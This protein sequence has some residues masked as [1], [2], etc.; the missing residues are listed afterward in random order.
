MGI[1]YYPNSTVKMR[2]HVVEKLQK[3]DVVYSVFGSHDLSG[4]ALSV[5]VWGPA[6]WEIK[7]VSL[8]FSTT[9]SKNYS[10]SIAHGVGIVSGKNDRLW[11]KVDAVPAQQVIVPQGFYSGS[12]LTDALETALNSADLSF[13]AESVPFSVSFDSENLLLIEPA[14]GKAKVLMLNPRVPVRRE[15]TLAPLLGFTQDSFNTETIVSDV[16]AV[17]MGLMDPKTVYLSAAGSAVQN[18]VGTD[19][20]AM[21]VDNQLLIESALTGGGNCI[22]TYEVVYKM[23]DA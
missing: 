23:L 10:L 15:S 13:P 14:V 4:G 12:D 6:G 8:N 20:V 3:P 16:D 21:S 18:I 5:G 19:T 22:V 7:R 1:T 11:V 9:T 2:T 17:T